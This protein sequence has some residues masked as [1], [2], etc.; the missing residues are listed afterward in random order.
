[1]NRNSL[2]IA[3]LLFIHVVYSGNN[4]YAQPVVS[5]AG[6][7]FPS[8]LYYKWIDEY[9]K[10]VP[11]RITYKETGSSEGIRLLLSREVDFGAT[12]VYPSESKE[13]QKTEE[14]L[15]IPTC[16]SALAIIYNLKDN[17][18]IRLTPSLLADIMMGKITSWSD[19]R[20]R[21][22]NPSINIQ[23][24]PITVVH[25]SEGSGTTFLLSDYLS[26]VS[27]EWKQK[28]GTGQKVSWQVGLGAQG[29]SGVARL[30][31]KIP[32]SI[33]YASLNYAIQNR[34]ST[35]AIQNAEGNYI[36][37]TVAS[38]SATASLDISSYRLINSRGAQSYPISGFTYIVLFRE[39]HYRNRSEEQVRALVRFLRWC[40]SEGHIYAAPLFYAPLPGNVRTYLGKMLDSI[41]YKGKPLS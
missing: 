32:G 38:V 34:L 40:I 37:P 41:T 14:F 16:I 35:A 20:I 28:I 6:A 31:K 3:L 5:G 4:L 29:N 11:S 36:K 21:D 24:S 17:Q 22:V 8:P 33:G 2:L 39:Q 19:Q 30:V 10:V 18:E 7:T 1:M 15:Y 26:L 12:D 25:R 27:V 9:G 23:E 13:R